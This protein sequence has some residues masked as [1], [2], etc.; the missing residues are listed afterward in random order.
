M[1]IATLSD[2]LQVEVADEFVVERKVS[3]V[4]VR[5]DGRRARSAGTLEDEIGTSFNR[6]SIG[7]DLWDAGEVEVIA[8]QVEAEG[9]RGGLVGGASRDDRIIVEEV[10]VIERNFT[11]GHVERGVELLNRLT[12]GGG[13]G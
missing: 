10:H 5:I 3:D 8:R 13:V 12:V 6:Q 4:D 9:A 1:Q 7:M 2:S 11:M